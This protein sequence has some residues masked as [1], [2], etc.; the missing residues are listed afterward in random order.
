MIYLKRFLGI[1][2][3]VCVIWLVWVFGI[4]TGI[5]D[6]SKFYQS[7]DETHWQSYS[8][9]AV[10]HARATGHGV[11]I[12]FTAD[13]CINCQVNDRLVLQ[14]QEVLK[15]FKDQG[16]IA[17]K[18]DW[19]KYDPVITRALASLGRNSIP[20]YVYYPP[21]ADSPNILPEL[22]TPHMILERIRYSK[23]IKR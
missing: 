7:S 23:S 16:I 9:S 4:Q 10:S 2:L 3:L 5:G 15:A 12:D 19:T 18:E 11:F 17:F 21:K 20:V 1:I 14:N 13:W 8:S 6:L 22:I